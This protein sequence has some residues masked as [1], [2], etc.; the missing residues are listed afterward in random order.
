MKKL[1]PPA[2]T[3]PSLPDSNFTMNWTTFY[4]YKITNR[5]ANTYHD[6]YIGLHSDMDL[7]YYKDD[8]VGC[9]S[10]LDA[11]FTYNGDLVDDL[12]DGYG[13]NPPMQD[14]EV[15]KGPLADANDGLDNNHNGTIDEP[16]ER[17]M[18]NHFLYFNN[19]ADPVNGNPDT[20]TDFYN[21][22]KGFWRNGIQMTYGGN[23]YGGTVPVNYMFS[24]TPYSGTGWSE[25]TAFYPPD[26]RRFI[27][28]SGP[29]SLTPGQETTIDFAY[30]FTWDSTAA[31][32]LTTSIA[33]NIADLQRIKQWFD[34]D[35]FPSCLVLNVGTNQI[36]KQN[37]TLNIQPNPAHDKLYIRLSSPITSPNGNTYDVIDLMGKTIVNDKLK[38]NVIDIRQLPEGLYILQIYNGDKIFRTKFVKQ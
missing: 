22:M 11:G 26:D 9:D 4:Q 23:G 28:S 25:Q 14:I 37:S 31:N 33:R 6:I 16:G 17:C 35:S 13:A 30:V 12:P 27:M 7:G 34:T 20:A 24:G 38:A 8:Y 15:L 29:F 1:E 10:T 32:G 5:S 2:Y 36:E 18:M 19:T 21:Y 3:C